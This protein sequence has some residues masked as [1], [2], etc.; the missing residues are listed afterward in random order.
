MNNEKTLFDIFREWT[1]EQNRKIAMMPPPG[2]PRHMVARRKWADQAEKSLVA[3]KARL[4][5]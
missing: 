3:L 1:D 5:G 4:L 2:H